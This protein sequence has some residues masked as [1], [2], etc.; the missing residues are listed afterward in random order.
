[1]LPVGLA[2]CDL[3]S[4]WTQFMRAAS[5]IPGEQTLATRG[6]TARRASPWVTQ[7]VQSITFGARPWIGMLCE[8]GLDG[9]R[10]VALRG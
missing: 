8:D 1:M 9:P 6:L 5:R 10:P 3:G 2:R 4:F 7:H